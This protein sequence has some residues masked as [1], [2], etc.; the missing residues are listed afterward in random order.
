MWNWV[1]ENLPCDS[2]NINKTLEYVTYDELVSKNHSID[3]KYYTKW[4]NDGQI[5]PLPPLN[6]LMIYRNGNG[7]DSYMCENKFI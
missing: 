2:I 5:T 7:K 6:L 1:R 4:G 3:F